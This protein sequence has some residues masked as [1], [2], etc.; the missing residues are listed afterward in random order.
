MTAMKKQQELMDENTDL[1]RRLRTRLH[2]MFCRKRKKEW[3]EK[4]IS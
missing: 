2:V 1:S 4:M 3:K